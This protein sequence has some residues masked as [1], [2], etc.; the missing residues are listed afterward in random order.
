MGPLY[1]SLS[2]AASSHPNLH[3]T[4]SGL[5]PPSA[6]ARRI[7]QRRRVEKSHHASAMPLAANLLDNLGLARRE[8]PAFFSTALPTLRRKLPIP[9]DWS[10]GCGFVEAL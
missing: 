6:P 3:L 7:S 4:G 2:S 9:M 8:T 1:R 5:A 10:P